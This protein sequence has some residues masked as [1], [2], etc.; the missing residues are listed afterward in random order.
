MCLSTFALSAPNFDPES[1]VEVGIDRTRENSCIVVGASG[2]PMV[3][4]WTRAS[5]DYWMNDGSAARGQL[6]FPSLSLG[7]SVWSEFDGVEGVSG[8]CDS[9]GLG[10]SCRVE[11][12]M[13]VRQDSILLGFTIFVHVHWN[14]VRSL[15]SR[16]GRVTTAGRTL[17]VAFL[18]PSVPLGTG[19]VKT[20]T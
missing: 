1:I 17:W 16:Q 14:S 12:A 9:G 5:K 2:S 15:S 7:G 8:A 6:A 20:R 13:G 10:D 18:S 4:V 19:T 11:S 3:A